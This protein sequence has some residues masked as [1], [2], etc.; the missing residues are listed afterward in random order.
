M[1][2]KIAIVSAKGL[3]IMSDGLAPNCFVHCYGFGPCSYDLGRTSTV[4]STTDPI[5]KTELSFPSVYAHH[6]SLYIVHSPKY[7]EDMLIGEVSIDL[8]YFDSGKAKEIPIDLTIKSETKATIKVLFRNCISEY[9][10]QQQLC[11]CDAFYICTSYLYPFC[12]INTDQGVPLEI[13]AI[14]VGKKASNYYPA[15]YEVGSTWKNL[16]GSSDSVLHHLPSGWT[17]VHRISEHLT[18]KSS[19]HFILSPKTYSGVICVH[20]YAAKERDEKR[21]NQPIILSENFVEVMK[22]NLTV[23]AGVPIST[24]FYIS[25]SEGLKLIKCASVEHNKNE[26]INVFDTR[27][28]ESTVTQEALKSMLTQKYKL[29]K[30]PFEVNYG[31]FSLP[32]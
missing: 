14:N 10:M 16:G 28:L 26:S 6:L 21:N 4:N 13:R 12:N 31:E 5:W 20:V 27:V 3:P 30:D 1:R 17:Q 15:F 11:F 19:T 24:P 23:Q 25:N 18:K 32:E 2:S 9:P 8:R 22:V 7:K 29:M